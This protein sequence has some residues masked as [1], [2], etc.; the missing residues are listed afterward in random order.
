MGPPS[1]MWFIVDLNV[2]MWCTIVYG[3]T[4]TKTVIIILTA[5]GTLNPKQSYALLINKG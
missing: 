2:I 5:V 4:P 1:Y 3:T